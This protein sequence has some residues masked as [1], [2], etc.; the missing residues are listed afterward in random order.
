MGGNSVEYLTKR[1]RDSG[2]LELLGAVE[3]GELSTYAAAEAAGIVKRRPVTGGGSENQARRRR[4]AVHLATGR[5]AL[6]PLP[7]PG[8]PDFRRAGEAQSVPASVPTMPDLAAAIREWEEAQRQAAKGTRQK[9]RFS[10]DEKC[11]RPAE[12]ELEPIPL[13][14]HSGI[15]C[16]SCTHPCAVAAVMELL[17]VALAARRGETGLA[18]SAMP[19]ACCRQQVTHIDVRSL[20]G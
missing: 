20:V 11:A 3:R 14:V 8:E 10:H 18:G 16:T 13:L 12:R 9:G 2:E 19:R 15:P 4:W 1:L 6:E 17:N 7:S 5:S